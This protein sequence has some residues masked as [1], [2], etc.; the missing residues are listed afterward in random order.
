MFASLFNFPG[1]ISSAWDVG[2]LAVTLAIAY[3]GGQAHK[4]RWVAYWS[5]LSA[6]G[7]I[8][9]LVPHWIYGPGEETYHM[10]KFDTHNSSIPKKGKNL[11]LILNFKKT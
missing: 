9:R 7:I 4:T 8:A 3:Y 11:I 6:A 1:I 10:G 5:I 2:A